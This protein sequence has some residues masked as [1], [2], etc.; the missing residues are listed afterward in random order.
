MP[1]TKFWYFIERSKTSHTK[2]S[3]TRS[4]GPIAMFSCGNSWSNKMASEQSPQRCSSVSSVVGRD[5]RW[6]YVLV[7]YPLLSQTFIALIAKRN[8]AALKITLNIAHYRTGMRSV[9]SN[10]GPKVF[11][12]D[13]SHRVEFVKKTENLR[14]IVFLCIGLSKQCLE[15]SLYGTRHFKYCKLLIHPWMELDL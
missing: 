12:C 3:T 15:S 11:F 4:E 7:R 5:R 14:Y 10:I 8:V 9:Q 6:D 1:V 13:W 2:Q